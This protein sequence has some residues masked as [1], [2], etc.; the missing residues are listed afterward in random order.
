MRLPGIVW[1]QQGLCSRPSSWVDLHH[2]IKDTVCFIRYINSE[3]ER[4]REM[5][6]NFEANVFTYI[7]IYIY[8]YSYMLR[9]TPSAAGPL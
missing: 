7:H 1:C 8:V 6:F 3:R 9:A 4:E 5:Q 2:F